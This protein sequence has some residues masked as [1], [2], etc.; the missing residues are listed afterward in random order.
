MPLKMKSSCEEF[1]SS[2]EFCFCRLALL[3]YLKAK[4]DVLGC[5]FLTAGAGEPLEEHLELGWS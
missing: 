4:A 1:E 3:M 2:R 5:A